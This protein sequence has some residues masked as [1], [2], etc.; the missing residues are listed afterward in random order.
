MPAPYRELLEIGF[1]RE[2][3]TGELQERATAILE[4]EIQL[5]QSKKA[6]E[7]SEKEAAESADAATP[8]GARA[9]SIYEDFNGAGNGSL[10]F[11]AIIKML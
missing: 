5:I 3:G 9:A 4:R 10:D 6:R 11:S 7:K 8:M 2:S 1:S